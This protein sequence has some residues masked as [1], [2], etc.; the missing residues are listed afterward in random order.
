M[1]FGEII[2][3]ILLTPLQLILET[4]YRQASQL[5]GNPGLSIIVLSLA[6]NLLLTPLY[7]RADAMQ[8]EEREIEKKLQKGVD[9]IKKTFQGDERMLI[10][11]TYYRENHYKPTYVLRGAAPLLLEIPFFIAAYRF[12]SGLTLL[13]GVS[14]GPIA[15]LSQPDGLLHIGGMAIN[16]LPFV[17]TGVNMISATLFTRD[18]LPREKIQLYVMAVFF[19]VFLYGSPSGLVFYWTLNNLF[20]LIKTILRKW[21]HSGAFLRT[22]CALVGCCLLGY[23][24][25]SWNGSFRHLALSLAAGLVLILPMAMHL[26]S[27]R[28]PQK[29]APHP[30]GRL[31]F[32]GACFLAVLLGGLIPSNVIHASVSEFINV[33]LYYSPVWYVVS[34]LCIAFGLFVLWLGIFYYLATPHSKVWFE[35]VIWCSCGIAVLD[36]MFFGTELGNL[37]PNLV[38]DFG[39]TF[40]RKEQLLNLAC[41]AVLIVAMLWLV[42]RFSRIRWEKILAVCTAAIVCMTAFN[43]VQIHTQSQETLARAQVSQEGD[44]T[45]TL[46]KNGQNV[47]VIMLDRGI[48][49]YIPYIFN[50]NPQLASQFSG[51]TYYPNNISFGQCTKLGTPSLFGGYEYTPAKMNNRQ[52]ML[53][54]EKHN[55]ALKVLPQLFADNGYQVTLFDPPLAGYQWTSD[56]TVFDGMENVTAFNTAGSF[57]DMVAS[58]SSQ[59]DTNRNFFCY[60]LTKSVPLV[61]QPLLY[62]NGNYNRNRDITMEQYRSQIATGAHTADGINLSFM[63]W[64]DVLLHMQS[65]T[66]ITEDG[67]YCLLMTNKV[68]HEP[69]LLSE[70]DYT[71]AWVV[72]NT[73]YDLEHADRFTLN[74]R[75][76]SMEDTADYASYQTNMAALMQ[77]G[78]WLD[79][80]R[81]NGIYDNTRIILVADHGSAL[82]QSEELILD[83]GTDMQ[84]V[85]ALLMVKDFNG[86]GSV[87]TDNTFMTVADVP[88]LVTNGVIDNPV[89]PFTGNS[90]SSQDKTDHDQYILISGDWD[91]LEQDTPTFHKG[92]WFSVHDDLW[93]KDNWQLVAKNDILYEEK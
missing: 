35:R 27:K 36:Y 54:S 3:T 73:Q 17:M 91:I 82:G 33:L 4:V 88:T 19:L 52:D 6:V 16:I 78:S 85:H 30:N 70:P 67:S 22:L 71:P 32:S 84:Q 42:Q 50:E 68:T 77:I 34:A 58:L 10:L 89:N 47:V 55:E 90:I 63:N 2:S 64:Y 25:L 87:T 51:F 93:N 9:H 72:D 61:L 49:T 74:G 43:T 8:E 59:E 7:Q 76:L 28:L 39:L 23:G 13:E 38:Y 60:S 12:L 45:F 15:D 81:E 48:N 65:M 18:S 83:T 37:S 86:T 24:V 62:D 20:S 79:Y 11:Q 92:Y 40:T 57:T 56:L 1:T 75:S 53:L 41:V 31:F 29:A 44:P 26:L 66:Q 80:L 46:S 14:F 21:K 5:L 69:I